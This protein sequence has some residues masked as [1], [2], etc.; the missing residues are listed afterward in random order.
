MPTSRG[1]ILII[2]CALLSRP[3]ATQ[4]RRR[5]LYNY[6]VQSDTIGCPTSSLRSFACHSWVFLRKKTKPVMRVSNY[7]QQFAHTSPSKGGR[8][9][10]IRVRTSVAY[11]RSF[12]SRDNPGVYATG[13]PGAFLVQ[14]SDSLA[15]FA[16]QLT[17]D[18]IS[19][20]AGSISK[21]EGSTPLRSLAIQ[22]L[23]PWIKNLPLFTDPCSKLHEPTGTRFRDC[24]RMIIDITTGEREVR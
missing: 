15:S 7:F 9:S 8:R 2:N 1:T 19:E 13:H 18:F 6:Q 4:S 24:V 3:F 14:I 12:S 16:P 17:M 22:Y 10:P 20:M 5:I 23:G 11:F 21:L